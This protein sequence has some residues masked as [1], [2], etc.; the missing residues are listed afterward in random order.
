MLP[1]TWLA[2][3]EFLFRF[4]RR[5]V[6]IY[7]Q[8]ANKGIPSL[9]LVMLTSNFLMKLLR[10]FPRYFIFQVFRKIFFIWDI[11]QIKTIVWNLSIR[12]FCSKYTKTN[13]LCSLGNGEGHYQLHGLIVVS[14]IGKM[15]L[16]SKF[17]LTKF[18]FWHQKL[19]HFH[20]VKV[21]SL[22]QGRNSMND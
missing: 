5:M 21:G 14:P 3:Q 12:D 18:E 22:S 11:L 7:V 9:T 20:K 15:N 2:I 6:I 19:G 16:V 17:S 10:V 8:L 1:T 4:I 13:Y